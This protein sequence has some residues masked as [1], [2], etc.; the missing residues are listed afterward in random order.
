MGYH[1]TKKPIRLTILEAKQIRTLLDKSTP[2]REIAKTMGRP[3][4]TIYAFIK[5]YWPECMPRVKL[6]KI[7]ETM[8][9]D[10]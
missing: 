3:N 1:K 10:K 5:K 9:I 2:I 4:A 7:C 8:R 6:K